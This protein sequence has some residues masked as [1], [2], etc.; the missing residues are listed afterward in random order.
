MDKQQLFDMI[1]SLRHHIN[2]LFTNTTTKVSL[3]EVN[4]LVRI[5]NEIL[6]GQRLNT[7]C[8]DCIKYALIYSS[9]YY[10]REKPIWDALNS[11]PDNIDDYHFMSPPESS[12][13]G[14]GVDLGQDNQMD[15]EVVT[16]GAKPVKRV[17]RKK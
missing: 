15:D 17:K 16:K 1:D 2:A 9:S 7:G 10:D 14:L 4:T 8:A 3:E 12:P 5:Y 13:V 11:I 6:P